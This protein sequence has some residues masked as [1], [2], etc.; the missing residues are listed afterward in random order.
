LF[1]SLKCAKLLIVADTDRLD[2][3]LTI[4]QMQGKFQTVLVPNATHA[5]HEDQ[6]SLAAD[7]VAGFVARYAR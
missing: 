1:L 2:T 6:P 3:E 7:A 4:A 5:V